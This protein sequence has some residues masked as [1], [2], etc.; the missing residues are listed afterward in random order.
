MSNLNLKA[1]DVPL[2]FNASILNFLQPSKSFSVTWLVLPTSASVTISNPGFPKPQNQSNSDISQPQN[3]GLTQSESLVFGARKLI[4]DNVLVK[5]C[6][7][8]R[9]QS[10]AIYL[11]QSRSRTDVDFSFRSSPLARGWPQSETES[12]IAVTLTVMLVRT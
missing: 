9:A 6:E 3:P 7:L 11:I 8:N 4:G 12:Q 5:L 1:F 2:P 10:I